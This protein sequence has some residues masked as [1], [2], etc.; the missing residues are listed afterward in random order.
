MTKRTVRL[1]SGEQYF[2]DKLHIYVNRNS[3]SYD[4]TEHY[5]DFLELSYVSEGTGTH[6]TGDECIQVSSGDLFLIPM[7]TSHVFRPASTAK[8]N[9]LIVYNCIV[10]LDMLNPL[11]SSFPGAHLL[12][13]LL[14]IPSIFHAQDHSGAAHQLFTSLY[15]EYSIERSEQE[16][17][18]YALLIQLLI[19]FARMYD[20]TERNNRIDIPNKMDNLLDLLQMRYAET[21]TTSQLASA[22]GVGERQFQRLFVKHTGMSLTQY[23]Q[24]IRVRAACEKLIT[25]QLKISSIAEAVGYMN[26][27]FFYEIFKKHTGY[28]PREYRN[29]QQNR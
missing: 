24:S 11:I 14:H 23:V 25:T 28:S 3:E 16:A 8:G 7:G 10:T 27:P 6:H 22:Y 9:P 20:G 21:F 1:L 13:R 4:L 15:R 12:Q 17:A 18:L 5:H 29:Q 26:T 19:L 2:N